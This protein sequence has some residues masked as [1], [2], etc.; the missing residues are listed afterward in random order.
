MQEESC[1]ISFQ[2]LENDFTFKNYNE[3]SCDCQDA[4]QYCVECKRQ[5]DRNFP[6]SSS[7]LLQNPWLASIG[8]V[9]GSDWVHDSIA[10]ET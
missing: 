5:E 10:S 3:T 4:C 8:Y 6:S 2:N 7:V 1:Q 9:S